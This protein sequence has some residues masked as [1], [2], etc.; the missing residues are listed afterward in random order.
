MTNQKYISTE[1]QWCPGCGNFPILATLVELM[2]EMNI[3]KN[4]LLFMGGIGQA[5]KLNQFVNGNGFSGLHG[6]VLPAATGVHAANPELKIVIN[7]GDGDSYGEG[8]NHLIHT[9]RRNPDLTHLVH[10]NQIYGLTTGQPS[11]TTDITDATVISPT[12]DAE[13]DARDGSDQDVPVNPSIPLKPLKLALAAGATFIARTFTGDREQL[14][15]IMQAAIEHKGYALVDIL[16]PCVTFN[17]VN[18]FK[19]YKDRV[20]PVDETHDVTDEKA[21]MELAD[22]WGDVIPTGI[23]YQVEKPVYTERRA[24]LNKGI[25]PA[26]EQITDKEI[27]DRLK[28]FI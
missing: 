2:N 28:T 12:T 8:G 21:A 18:T 6:R 20:K 1:T 19:W 24:V 16:Q 17:K 26:R 7:S 10:N 25:I 9:I 23:L 14:K 3:P 11:P 15:E 5:A 4:D 13:E 27:E 22:T